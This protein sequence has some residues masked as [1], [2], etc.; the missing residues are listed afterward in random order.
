[1]NPRKPF[2][3]TQHS[4]V[5]WFGFAVCLLKI[6]LISADVDGQT[7]GG[8]GLSIELFKDVGA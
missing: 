7:K 8:Q 4:P 2:L 5:R 3:P 6:L 1:M